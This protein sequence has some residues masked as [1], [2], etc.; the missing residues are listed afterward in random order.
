MS[1]IVVFIPP[2][3]A[4][5][6]AIS[7]TRRA[8]ADLYRNARGTTFLHIWLARYQ[9]RSMLCHELLLQPDSVLEDAGFT[10]EDAEREASK[11]FWLG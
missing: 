8:V 7:R 2:H 5:T 11:P 1:N 3:S 6:A 9:L 4:E 10:R